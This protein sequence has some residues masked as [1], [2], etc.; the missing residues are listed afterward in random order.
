MGN[1]NCAIDANAQAGLQPRNALG[2]TE[3]REFDELGRV[4]RIT[5]ALN[6]V[7]RF[8]YDL[9]GNRLSITDADNRTWRFGYDSLGRLTSET[10][11]AGKTLVYK[12]DEAG[13]VIERVNRLGDP[14]STLTARKLLICLD[15]GSK[16]QTTKRAVR[17]R[18][19]WVSAVEER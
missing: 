19:G 11:H 2:C 5:D 7:T 12:P 13:N 14:S 8:S 3:H 15:R 1:P 10:D 16:A 17:V 4:T 6:G 9:A 18:Q